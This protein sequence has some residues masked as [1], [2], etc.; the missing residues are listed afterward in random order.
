[1]IFDARINMRGLPLTPVR[2]VLLHNPVPDGPLLGYYRG[3]PIA[4]A[5][6]DEFGR[7]YLYA[8]VGPRRR[9]GRIDEESLRPGEWL[10]ESGLIYR[11]D[12]RKRRRQ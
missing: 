6:I 1:M 2:I 9:D 4:S 8:G 3:E 11:W 7:R 12:D 10:T 5:V